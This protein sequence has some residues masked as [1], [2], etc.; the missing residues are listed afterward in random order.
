MVP[1]VDRGTV[2]VSDGWDRSTCLPTGAQTIWVHRVLESGGN[3]LLEKE[4]MSEDR[5][6]QTGMDD[7]TLKNKSSGQK[8]YSTLL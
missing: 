3:E 1:G 4:E 6:S 8:L 7:M 5:N 2:P